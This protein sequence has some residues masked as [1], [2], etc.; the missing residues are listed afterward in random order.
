MSTDKIKTFIESMSD[1]E[2]AYAV[3]FGKQTMQSR[4]DERKRALD[5][6]YKRLL[7]DADS[8]RKLRLGKEE[9]NAAAA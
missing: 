5:A 2:I 6:D 1:D 3:A 8:G 4:F 7:K 9:K